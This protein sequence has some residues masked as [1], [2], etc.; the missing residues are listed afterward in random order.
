MIALDISA[1]AGLLIITLLIILPFAIINY[2]C[3]EFVVTDQRVIIKVGFISRRTL[4][5]FISK[6]ESIGIDQNIL[7]RLLG[8]GT[9]TVRGTGGSA[10]KFTAIAHPLE[11]RSCVQNIQTQL[12]SK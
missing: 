9:V 6:I 12:E 8:Y 10:E 1:I 11:F 5:M 3:S 7:G 4:E 2:I